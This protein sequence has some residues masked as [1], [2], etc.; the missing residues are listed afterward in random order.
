MNVR[1]KLIR[2]KRTS[3]GPA[4]VIFPLIFVVAFMGQPGLLVIFAKEGW[5]VLLWG[6]MLLP[7]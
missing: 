7:I 4:F 2:C 5:L 1:N 6:I 3:T